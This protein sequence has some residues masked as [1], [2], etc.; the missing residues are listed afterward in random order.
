MRANARKSARLKTGPS[1]PRWE[2]AVQ[3]SPANSL[4]RMAPIGHKHINMRGI[5]KFDFA[6]HASGLFRH[7]PL[8]NNDRVSI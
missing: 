8:T 6:R 7:A 2:Y 1:V 4:G 3:L 5:L